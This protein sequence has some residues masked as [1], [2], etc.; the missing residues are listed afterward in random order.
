M[1]D[2]TSDSES[3]Y[4][5]DL[6]T[7]DEEQIWTVIDELAPA[8]SPQNCPAPIVPE[9]P[10]PGTNSS[11]PARNTV[12]SN[13]FDSDINPDFDPDASLVDEVVAAI[14]D[15]DLSFDATE[16]QEDNDDAYGQGQGTA[17]VQQ[18]ATRNSTPDSYDRRLAPSVAGDDD[19]LASFVATTKPR[20]MPTLLP[21]PDI[22]YPDCELSPAA[23]LRK[24]S[25]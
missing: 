15:D 3:D 9:S 10:A 7:S 24:S 12:A 13:L 25:N 2:F 21:G 19:G 16:L 11:A 5:Y 23:S 8:A 17:Y 22:S 18:S 6:T 1:A 20:S 14:T 4:G